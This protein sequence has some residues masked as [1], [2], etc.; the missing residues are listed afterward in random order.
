[1]AELGA[2]RLGNLKLQQRLEVLLG[3]SVERGGNSPLRVHTDSGWRMGTDDITP[4]YT[5]IRFY[6]LQINIR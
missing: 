2:L 3:R 1:M 6:K 5:G 4:N